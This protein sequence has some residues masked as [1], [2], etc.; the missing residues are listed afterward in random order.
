MADERRVKCDPAERTLCALLDERAD[1]P[2]PKRRGLCRLELTPIRHNGGSKL[3]AVF[4]RTGP[5][6]RGVAFNF[7]PYC[8]TDLR[9]LV[10]DTPA[11]TAKADASA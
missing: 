2:L 4:Y 11:E 10:D 7:C 5:S 3:R 8:G 1:H 9:P 6:D